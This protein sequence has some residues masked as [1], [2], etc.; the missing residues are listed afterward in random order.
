MTTVQTRNAV[1]SVKER[2]FRMNDVSVKF[3]VQLHLNIEGKKVVFGH[4]MNGGRQTYRMIG[5]EIIRMSKQEFANQLDKAFLSNIKEVKTALYALSLYCKRGDTSYRYYSSDF[6]VGACVGCGNMVNAANV[7]YLQRN[8]AKFD[9]SEFSLVCH[10]CQPKYRKGVNANVNT[11]AKVEVKPEVIV[12]EPKNV[13]EDVA[14]LAAVNV[15]KAAH[16]FFGEEKAMRLTKAQMANKAREVFAH[17]MNRL[18]ASEASAVGVQGESSPEGQ[19]TCVKEELIAA[20]ESTEDEF[21]QALEAAIGQDI[22][23]AASTPENEVTLI[24]VGAGECE[25]CDEMHVLYGNAELNGAACTSCMDSFLSSHGLIVGKILH[26]TQAA[27]EA[28]SSPA[29]LAVETPVIDNPVSTVDTQVA[30]DAEEV[31]AL[32]L[33]DHSQA[34]TATGVY[35]LGKCIVCKRRGM[36]VEAVTCVCKQCE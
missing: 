15:L 28:S 24:Y 31:D 8:I 26:D 16:E 17:V 12:E 18:G 34:S 21:S 35:V 11:N 33:A 36:K 6:L 4:S 2:A 14:V 1:V 7:D 32:A 10:A 20:G 13:V 30:D 23:E 25:I 19:E 5:T 29:P 9:V 27:S 3:P 22:A